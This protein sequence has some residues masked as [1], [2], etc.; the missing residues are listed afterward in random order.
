MFKRAHA[1][2]EEIIGLYFGDHSIVDSILTYVYEIRNK[3]PESDGKS[4]YGGWQKSILNLLDQ[5][6][7]LKKAIKSE[8]KEYLKYYCVEKPAYLDFT[9]LFCNINPPGSSN[10][11]H[12]H[13]VGEFSGTL[14]IQAEQNS[15][16]LIIMNPFSNRFMNTCVIPSPET[17]D[18]NAI[19]IDPEPNKGVFFNSNLVHY[20]DINRSQKDRV[21]IA[22]NI[23]IRY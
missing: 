11:M 23:G 17:R 1:S 6:H 8:F 15:G 3:Y 9:A 4:N 16:Q 2:F 18:Y 7:P 20:V 21:S 13:L 19:H 14:W 10:V 12:H 5:D 22:Y